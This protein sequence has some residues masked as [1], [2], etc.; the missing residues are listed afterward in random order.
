MGM[1]SVAF[2]VLRERPS[3]T[4]GEARARLAGDPRTGNM[5]PDHREMVVQSTGLPEA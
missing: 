5:S 4:K 2:D 1:V 3:R